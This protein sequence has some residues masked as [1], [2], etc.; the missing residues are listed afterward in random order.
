MRKGSGRKVESAFGYSTPP[1]CYS[2]PSRRYVD[3]VSKRGKPTSVPPALCTTSK[4]GV[5]ADDDARFRTEVLMEIESFKRFQLNLLRPKGPP[6]IQESVKNSVSITASQ[7]DDGNTD[8][9]ENIENDVEDIP[10]MNLDLGHSTLSS[11]NGAFATSVRD[12]SHVQLQ[13]FVPLSRSQH[14]KGSRCQCHS[15]QQRYQSATW[16][17]PLL[18]SYFLRYNTVGSQERFPRKRECNCKGGTYLIMEYR[19][20]Q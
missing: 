6:E 17:Q 11:G 20:P 12:S 3:T 19:L 2:I 13:T 10:I 14:L 16:F 18:G 1:G 15:S 9:D 8:G 5:T 7:P 4:G